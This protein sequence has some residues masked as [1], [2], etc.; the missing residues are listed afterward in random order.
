MS[1]RRKECRVEGEEAGDLLI[2]GKSGRPEDQKKKGSR[3][4][5][6]AR[7]RKN[8]NRWGSQGGS[9]SSRN[10]KIRTRGP[11]ETNHEQ[12]YPS[13]SMDIKWG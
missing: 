7:G 3:E 8:L 11:G 1:G 5:F 4:E 10:G 6:E 13:I 12:G 2:T 9:L